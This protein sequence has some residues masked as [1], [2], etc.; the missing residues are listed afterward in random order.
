MLPIISG[1]GVEES[2]DPLVPAAFLFRFEAALPKVGP[3]VL[4]PPF[5]LPRK[6]TLPQFAGL[7]GQRAFASITV[8]WTPD[9]LAVAVETE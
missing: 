2:A 4:E 7:D 1:A 9:G 3:G 8:G 5:D 6:A